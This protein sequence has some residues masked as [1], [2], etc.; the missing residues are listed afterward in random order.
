M[1]YPNPQPIPPPTP[2]PS[3]EAV[4]LQIAMLLK[5]KTPKPAIIST[6]V[7]QG[8]DPR[9]ATAAVEQ[10]EIAIRLKKRNDGLKNMLYGA[11]W[12]IGGIVVSALS[13]ESASGGGTYYAFYGAVIIGAIQF[14]GGLIQF[15][16]NV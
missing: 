9:S 6:L 13:Y 15:L 10:M 8:M 4:F 2:Q 14:L 12:C 11:L 16:G 1:E 7:Q 3:N 5:N